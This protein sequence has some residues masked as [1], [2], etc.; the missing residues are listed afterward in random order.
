MAI[1][2]L[3]EIFRGACVFFSAACEAEDEESNVFF[4]FLPFREK[5]KRDFHKSRHPPEK[6]SENHAEKKLLSFPIRTLPLVEESHLVGEGKKNKRREPCVLRSDASK[7]SK[8]SG[9]LLPFI[10]KKDC[11][12]GLQSAEELFSAVLSQTILPVW[13]FTI[14]QRTFN[15]IQNENPK[16][17]ECSRFFGSGAERGR[18]AIISS[19]PTGAKRLSAANVRAGCKRSRA[20]RREILHDSGKECPVPLATGYTDVPD[21][22]KKIGNTC[23]TG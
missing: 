22:P 12:S 9:C 15:D 6:F 23:N 14:S 5:K 13:T 18:R 16:F 17:N 4:I 1:A 21:L 8:K 11:L 10:Y 2:C 3:S 7:R 20:E 19:V